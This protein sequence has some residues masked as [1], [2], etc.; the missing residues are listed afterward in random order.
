[1][2]LFAGMFWKSKMEDESK[3]AI[4]DC[5]RIKTDVN[6]NMESK[7]TRESSKPLLLP[8]LDS[9]RAKLVSS[10]RQCQQPSLRTTNMS[11]SPS[12]SA[13]KP[14]WRSSNVFSP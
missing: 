13:K 3:G 11:H 9:V 7:T 5:G 6:I 4:Q 10:A 1:M 8:G 14:Y 2:K 12:H